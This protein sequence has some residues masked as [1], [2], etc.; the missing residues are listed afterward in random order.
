MLSLTAK[1]RKII[2]KKAKSLRKEGMTPAILY[3]P[4][5]KPL[6]LKVDLKDLKKVYEEGGE[7]SLVSLKIGKKE[8]KV[9]IH[10]IQRHPV[11][12]EFLH[13]DFYAPS[14]KEKVTAT[15]PLAFEGEA[16]AVKELGGVL[17]K[18]ISEVTV[19][20]K[21]QD[22][23]KEIKVNIEGLKTFEDIILIKDLKTKEGVQ[24]LKEPEEVVASVVPPREE[25]V[26]EEVVEEA[27]PEE[28]PEGEKEEEMKE[29]SK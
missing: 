14:L 17:V 4:K 24:I 8:E 27:A 12:D 9:L 6:P 21:P 10:E 28:K 13:V 5:I 1:T 25:E 22:L 18:N 20:A 3:G 16:L 11:T 19:E 26:A 15:I 29:G 23:P 7:S 2:G